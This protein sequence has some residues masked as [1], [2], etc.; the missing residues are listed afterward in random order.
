MS[1]SAFDDPNS[2]NFALDV[3]VQEL[4]RSDS[5]TPG[6]P[7][8]FDRMMANARA[9]A[10]KVQPVP[11]AHKVFICCDYSQIEARVLAWLAGQQDILDVFAR[12]EDVYVYTAGKIGSTNRQL[13]KVCV[14][15][16]GFG[17]GWSKFIA[18]AKLMGE[19]DLDETFA[20]DTVRNWRT[21]NPKIVRLWYVLDDTFRAAIVA[22]V[23]ARLPVGDSPLTIERGKDAIGIM[24]PSQKRRLIYRNPRLVP[25]E[26][27]F[28]ETKTDIHYDGI[29]QMSKK[30]G[31]IKTYGGKLAENVTQ[32]TARDVMAAGLLEMDS[33]GLDLRMTVHDEVIAVCA[34]S[35]ASM[36]LA[37][38]LGIMR[39]APA[40]AEGLPVW[41]EGWTGKRYKK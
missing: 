6:D 25:N 28:H 23:G 36:K 20:Q 21:S 4:R 16:L 10:A 26:D 32:A 5:F 33:I 18:T 41:A 11:V 13:G 37:V 22:P 27:S 8:V 15:G 24:L 39:K 30:W 38:M 9:A 34:E 7:L 1:V 29:Q 35:E 40:W 14:L 3:A 2:D 17:M 31:P 19:L 12:N